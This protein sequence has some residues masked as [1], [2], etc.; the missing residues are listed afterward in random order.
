MTVASLCVE[1]AWQARLRW[2]AGWGPGPELWRSGCRRGQRAAPGGRCRAGT[3]SSPAALTQAMHY[4]H[5]CVRAGERGPGHG[6]DSTPGG[7]DGAPVSNSPALVGSRAAGHAPETTGQRVSTF[8]ACRGAVCVLNTAAS[9]SA[10]HM[11]HTNMRAY[12]SHW[13]HA[14]AP[15]ITCASSCRPCHSV[16]SRWAPHSDPRPLRAPA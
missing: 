7:P 8:L 14:L 3:P 11:G 4:P 6:A 10:M 12:T 15:H 2:R 1:V 13:P 16:C 9:G 5:G